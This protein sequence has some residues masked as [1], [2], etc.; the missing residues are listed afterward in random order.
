MD[1]LTEVQN[2]QEKKQTLIIAIVVA[3]SLV[4]LT[5]WFANYL[6]FDQL[7]NQVTVKKEEFNTL[8]TERHNLE[9]IKSNLQTLERNSAT[10]EDDYK[11]LSP[12]IPEEKE[13]PDIL[14]YLYQAGTN[15][16]L[17]LSHF[18]QSQKISR[19]GALN[20]LPITVSVLGS[21]DDILRYLNDFVRF[22]R[23]LNVDNVKITEETNPKYVGNMNAQIKFSAYLSDPNAV[24]IAATQKVKQ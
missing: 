23:I 4:Y 22:K 3:I 24:A 20:Q 7:S 12:L 11:K 17:R 19:Q 5:N 16:S 18:S 15:R 13:L 10:L 6:Y 14:A 1:K 2:P 9:Q 8:E 21:D